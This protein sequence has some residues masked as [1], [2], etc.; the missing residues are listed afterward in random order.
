MRARLVESREIAPEVRRLVF[1]LPDRE[2]LACLPG[3]WVSL[4]E[5]VGGRTATRAYSLAAMPQ[6]NRFEL[7]LNRVKEGLFSPWLF[8]LV[9]GDSLEVRGPLGTFTPR[10][11]FG[12][13]VFIA[14]GTGI[15]P[16]RAFLQSDE[17]LRAPARITLLFGARFQE[18]ILYRQE[19][20]ALERVR[21]GFRFLPTLT[22]PGPGWRGG[23]GRVQSHLDD[24][25]QGRKDLDVYICGLKTMVNEVRALLRERGFDKN[26]VLHEKYD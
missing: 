12:D 11:P 2:N 23:V 17:V 1:V 7:C 24:V 16:F 19:F 20:E 13:S 3:Q 14:T 8:Q 26:R 6:G 9:P 10:S 25:L 4:S 18:S 22:R 15:A 21:P 5:A